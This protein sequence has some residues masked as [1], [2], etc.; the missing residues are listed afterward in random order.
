MSFSFANLANHLR[1]DFGI[2]DRSVIIDHSR[3]KGNSPGFKAISFTSFI[4]TVKI[5]I[6]ISRILPM[7][8]AD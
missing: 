8:G 7:N 2:I 6:H 1:L 5:H 4:F 3:S